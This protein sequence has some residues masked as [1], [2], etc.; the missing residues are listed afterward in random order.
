MIFNI[1]LLEPLNNNPALFYAICMCLG[2]SIGSFLNVVIYRLPMILKEEWLRDYKDSQGTKIRLKPAYSIISPGSRCPYCEHAIRPIDNIPVLSFLLLRGKCRSCHKNISLR[3]PL[4]ELLT[5]LLFVF[6][7]YQL[8]TSIFTFYAW[9]LIALLIAL[10]FIDIDTHLLPDHL[11]ISLLWLGLTIN[12][13]G[14]FVDLKSAVMGAVIGYL[15]LWSIF[16]L[17]KILTGKEGMGYGDFKLLSALGAWMGWQSLLPIVI[18]SS[19]IGSVIGIFL[20]LLKIN[21]KSSA[22]PFGPFLSIAGL[23]VFFYSKNINQLFML[24]F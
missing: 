15:I 20:I 14:G 9:I 23:V 18:I 6:T 21:Q 12:I 1:S 11:T 5:G 22:L 10:T 16:W 3:Y 17:F 4:I 19:M 7:S 2:L 8:G 24:S 13:N